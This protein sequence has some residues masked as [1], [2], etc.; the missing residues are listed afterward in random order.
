[1]ISSAALDTERPVYLPL[2]GPHCLSLTGNSTPEEAYLDMSMESER[3]SG[4][5]SD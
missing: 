3:M 5:F 4:N 1:M 2:S